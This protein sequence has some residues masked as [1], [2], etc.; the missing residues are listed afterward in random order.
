MLVSLIP[1]QDDALEKQTMLC[2]PMSDSE[3]AA[4]HCLNFRC[5]AHSHVCPCVECFVSQAVKMKVQSTI[6]KSTLFQEIPRFRYLTYKDIS[7]GEKLGE[8][9]YAIVQTCALNDE[10]ENCN[11]A[12]KY[13]KNEI[14][15]DQRQL[16]TAAADMAN[17]AMLLS[18]LNHPNIVK[19]IAV[20]GQNNSCK[21]EEGNEASCFLVLERLGETLHTRMN[22]WRAM[23][24]TR[25]ANVFHRLSKEFKD[26]QKTFLRERLKAALQIIEALEYLHENRIVFR[27]LKPKNI[28]FD[29]NGSLKLIDFGLAKELKDCDKNANGTYEMSG[30]SGS[31]RYMAPE[32]ALSQPYNE[33]VDV[34]AFG[35]VLWEIC[36]MTTCF[37]DLSRR[38]HMA[39]VIK[40]GR[41]PRTEGFQW[42]TDLK[43]LMK[44][45]WAVD[46]AKR[47]SS[48]EAK[49]ALKDVLTHLDC[50][51]ESRS[52]KRRRNFDSLTNAT[53]C[54]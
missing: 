5:E 4:R 14:M 30:D 19:L 11:A 48:T 49:K 37:P 18:R 10:P 17:E 28:A 54:R 35:V 13:L 39:Y 31:R 8:G 42:P 16:K 52:P 25:S 32:A 44:S 34:Y 40:R 20:S 6:A 33:S 43:A 24:K 26:L 15:I 46:P 47:P 29:R 7:I 12:I 9:S 2:A 38:L 21:S 1:T 41:R 53:K 45:C 51:G 22:Q 3:N 36:S 50:S 23:D 27:D